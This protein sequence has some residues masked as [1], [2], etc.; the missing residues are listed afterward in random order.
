M[1]V[2]ITN[3]VIATWIFSSVFFIALALSIRPRIIAAWFPSSVSAELKGL[4]ILMIVLSHIGYFLVSDTRFLWPLSIA[5][6]V[7]VNLFLF[8]SG[9]GL[10]VSQLQKDLSIWQFYKRRLWKLFVPFWLML[11]TFLVLDFFVL[12]LTYPWSYIGR[13]VSGIFNR[14]DLY[15]DINS[16][17]WYLTFILGYYIL[18]PLVFSRRRAWLSALLLYLAGYLFVYFEPAFFNNVFHLYKIHIIAFPLGV[19]AAWG[20][21]RLPAAESLS[22]WSRGRTAILYYAA[23]SACLAIFVYANINSGIGGSANF[24]Q[25]MSL[26]AVLAIV[27]VFILK[28]VEFR[29]LYWFGIYSYEIYLWHWPILYR[30]DIFYRFLPDTWG[31][32]ATILYLALFLGLGRLM[33]GAVEYISWL[34]SA[35]RQVPAK[36]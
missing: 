9:F 33:S 15:Q 12:H 3:P 21:G 20:L 6:G 1:I 7:G 25:G 22:G 32:L 30:Y 8:L 24:E 11:L 16:P 31:W 26:I 29:L 14:A 17:L 28:K 36:K 5:A 27:G 19:L 23:L 34:W 13:A 2:S 10:T 18:F 35:A 4:A